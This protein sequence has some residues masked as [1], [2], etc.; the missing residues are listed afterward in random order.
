[1][2]SE[3]Q[4]EE[5]LMKNLDIISPGLTLISRQYPTKYGKIDLLCHHK[6]GYHVVIEVK[7]YA[8]TNSPGQ[9]AKYI[10]AIKQKYPWTPVVGILVS[11]QIPKEV[12]ELC[13]YFG[14]LFREIKNLNLPDRHIEV[15]TLVNTIPQSKSKKLRFRM[16]KLNRRI[17]LLSNS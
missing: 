11:Q 4:M 1:M 3:Y 14:L 9:L 17:K 5:F 12:W 16:S 15:T 13:D 8:D 7:T 2:T 10:F 6:E